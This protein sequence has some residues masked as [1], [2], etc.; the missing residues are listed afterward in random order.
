[1]TDS[2][3]RTGPAAE[4]DP[5]A[6][7]DA[8]A[9]AKGEAE[10]G[11]EAEGEAGAEAGAGAGAQAQA[12]PR[13]AVEPSSAART[14]AHGEHHQGAAPRPAPARQYREPWQQWQPRREPAAWQAE[15]RPEP[16]A[17]IRTATLWSSLA[18]ALL[19]ALLLR[20]G[21]G[22]NLLFVAV[23]AA[24]AAFFAARAAGR[25][26]RPWTLVW[27]GGGLVLLAVPALRDAGLPVFLAVVSAVALGALALHG[28]R[29][30]PGV[31]LGPVGLVGAVGPGA[32]WA[33][34]GLRERAGGTRGRVVPVLRALAV[35]AV[36][37]VVFGTLFASADAAFAEL[38]GSL[39]PDVSDS[40]APSQLLLFGFGLCGAL[41]AAHTAASP[42]RWDRV[43]VR[44][45]KARGRTEWALPLIVL[46]LLF[47]AFIAVQLV[48]LLGGYD[49]VVA[50]TGL[51]P[52]QY[53][54]QGFWQ[55]LWVTLLVLVVIVA[56]GRWAPRGGARDAALVRT[57]LGTLCVLTLVVVAAAL[58]RM[59]LYVEAFGLT[60]LRVSVTA[61]ELWLGLV[62]VL[63]LVAG[64]TRGRWLPRAVA[65]SA[66]AAVLAFG[67]VSPDALVAERNVQRYER[68]HKIDIEYFR[69][70]SADAVPALDRL[71]EPLRS[72]ALR[73]IAD[74][75]EPGDEPWYATSLAESRARDLLAERG[76]R[77]DVTCPGENRYRW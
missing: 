53:A 60:R 55:L 30:W 15:V 19:S 45:G 62:I 37:L 16:P 50:E 63:M 23:P 65:A 35:A 18:T 25:L 58:R 12:E 39:I 67:L 21:L 69:E 71:P 13:D 4:P 59:D 68:T 47:A 70:L 74:G 33:L 75:L 56:A 22:L 72:C 11:A 41:A 17:R 27:A 40:G 42:P 20:E 43:T 57:V 54:R 34:R 28:S 77:S 48:V 76:V 46:N 2:P 61:V 36:L 52:A 1:M 49:R 29:T 6:D 64:A 3:S 51:T 31:L 10:A 32:V 9:E 5:P 44:P 38:L 14:R 24:L 8:E 7:A 26:P 73:G 66:G